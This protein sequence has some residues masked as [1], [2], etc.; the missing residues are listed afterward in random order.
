[1][2]IDPS[3][4]Q[5]AEAIR[6]IDE[7][8]RLTPEQSRWLAAVVALRNAAQPV[9]QRWH[10]G[11]YVR[12]PLFRS[13][14]QDD[15]V[16]KCSSCGN[17]VPLNTHLDHCPRCDEPLPGGPNVSDGMAGDNA[18]F[19]HK[20][21]LRSY[22]AA[23]TAAKAKKHVP[24]LSSAIALGSVPVVTKVIRAVYQDS[25]DG[26]DDDDTDG[27]GSG[28]SSHFGRLMVE[29]AVWAAAIIANNPDPTPAQA[30]T[31]A[32]S[33]AQDASVAADAAGTLD[34]AEANQNRVRFT[35]DS[36]DA[37]QTCQDAQETYDPA[38]D[39][40]PSVPLHK[41]CQCSYEEVTK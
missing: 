18:G 8:C 31:E 24:R 9:E 5:S 23:A 17:L 30:D 29:A 28:G 10:P 13:D 16:I 22:R 11:R 37:C 35:L 3:R 32:A 7:R 19:D 39:D 4:L 2:K 20:I 15:E 36:S 40:L 33:V 26:P 14:V 6:R 34:T 1:M 21:P 25:Y 27:N 41:G 12:K 38:N